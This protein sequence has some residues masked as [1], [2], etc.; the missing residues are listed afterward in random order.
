MGGK[1]VGD[2]RPLN[3]FVNDNGQVKV[4]NH[5]SWPSES[6]NYEKVLYN[7]EITYLCK[8]QNIKLLKKWWIWISAK[9]SQEVT[10]KYARHFQLGWLCLIVQS[11]QAQKIYITWQTIGSIM[12]DWMPKSNIYSL[13]LILTKIWSLSLL[14]FVI[15]SQLFDWPR[16]WSING[17][18]STKII[19][20]KLNLLKSD[21]FLLSCRILSSI[22]R[23]QG[24][25]WLNLLSRELFSNL[26][27]M[28]NL[29][30]SQIA[31]NKYW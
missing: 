20:S 3:I 28:L 8:N 19:S 10:S 4:A 6:N 12:K 27:S 22:S 16:E 21:K 18:Y 2:I 15:L 7:K 26:L 23:Y 11:Y 29:K 30:L 24:N 1:K 5:L 9:L 17:F 31:Q 14:G 13:C 25:L